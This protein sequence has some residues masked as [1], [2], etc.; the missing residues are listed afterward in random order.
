MIFCVGQHDE[1]EIL[2][3]ANNGG[4]HG[5]VNLLRWYY[6]G[7]VAIEEGDFQSVVLQKRSELR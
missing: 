6:I 2:L 1:N 5:S 7:I 3:L 4:C